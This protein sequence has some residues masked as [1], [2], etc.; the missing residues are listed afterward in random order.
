MSNHNSQRLLSAAFSDVSVMLSEVP[1]NVW[2][3]GWRSFENTHFL[4]P[5]PVFQ[6]FF[7]D[8]NSISLFLSCLHLHDSLK[9]WH[10]GMQELTCSWEIAFTAVVDNRGLLEGGV[11]G[12]SPWGCAKSN[13]KLWSWEY[14]WVWANV[15][16]P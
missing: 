2:T 9:I 11:K 14:S 4:S 8:H 3:R 10:D 7:P 1:K 12:R 13:P 16:N 15:W 5:P 6:S